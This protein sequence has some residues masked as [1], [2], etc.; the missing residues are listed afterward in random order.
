M[1]REVE[2]KNKPKKLV[3]FDEKKHRHPTLHVR[4]GGSKEMIELVWTLYQRYGQGVTTHHNPS[5]SIDAVPHH[6]VLHMKDMLFMHRTQ[7]QKLFIRMKHMS[8]T[9]LA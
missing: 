2:K 9:I 6:L 7:P 1:P 5:I 3:P 8:V 4:A